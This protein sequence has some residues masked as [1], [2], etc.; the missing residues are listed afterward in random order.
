MEVK[1]ALQNLNGV[2]NIY[3]GTL[4]EHMALQESLK[5]LNDLIEKKNEKKK[6][7]KPNG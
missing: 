2:C 7:D 5:T 1:V 4:Q 6:N 3:K